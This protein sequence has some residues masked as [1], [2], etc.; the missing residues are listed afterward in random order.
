MDLNT[1]EPTI[2]EEITITQKPSTP[3][4]DDF[5]DELGFPN[6]LTIISVEGT[7]V[8]VENDELDIG[9]SI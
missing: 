6:T 9:N 7:P 4:D 3:N 5:D 8:V 2:Q 1:N